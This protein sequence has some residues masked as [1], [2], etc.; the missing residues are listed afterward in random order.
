MSLPYFVITLKNKYVELDLTVSS[1]SSHVVVWY[2]LSTYRGVHSGTGMRKY[3]MEIL[4]PSSPKSARIPL[5][6]MPREDVKISRMNLG[7]LSI[8]ETTKQRTL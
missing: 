5:I 6:S 8:E 1:L 7:C 3:L 2:R 4:T